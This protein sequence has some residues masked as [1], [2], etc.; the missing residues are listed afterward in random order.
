MKKLLLLSILLIVGCDNSPTESNTKTTFMGNVYVQTGGIGFASY[1]FNSYDS[2][3]IDYSDFNINSLDNGNPFPNKKL[4]INKEFDESNGIFSGLINWSAPENS[5]VNNTSLWAYK[6]YFSAD[7]SYVDSG[8]VI[9]YSTNGD[10]V[11][12]A[13]YGIDL[14]YILSP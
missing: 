7:Y 8:S 1:H 6:M 13:Y 2:V 3:Y 5:S 12:T 14:I 4:F 9:V 11:Y 10:S